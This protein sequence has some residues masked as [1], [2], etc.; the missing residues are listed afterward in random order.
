MFPI[1]CLTPHQSHKF[2]VVD[3]TITI[4]I[5]NLQKNML[6]YVS[7]TLHCTMMLFTGCPAKKSCLPN[8]TG[9]T[10]SPVAGTPYYQPYQL[11]L[12]ILHWSLNK[13]KCSQVPSHVHGQI[14]PHSTQFWL[15]FWA[16]AAFCY[17]NPFWDSLY[18]AY[19]MT[20]LDHILDVVI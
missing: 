18:I 19:C 14:G 9:A 8:A 3:V 5:S 15:D 2:H 13:V 12:E 1:T 7:C 17:N 10:Q 16:P 20:H 11:D 4:F 6:Y